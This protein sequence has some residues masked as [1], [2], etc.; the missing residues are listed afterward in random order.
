ISPRF[1]QDKISNALVSDKS[2]SSIN[3]FMVL[4]E[5]EAGVRKPSL[6]TN[7]EQ[8][9]RYRELLAA[10]RQEYEDTV[11]TAVERASSADEDGRGKRCA[12]YIDNG[13]ADTQREEV[14]NKYTGQYEEPG[15]RVRRSSE[16]KID[17]AENRQGDCRREIM[18]YIG[19]LAIE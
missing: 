18:N 14:R 15:E 10:V 17:V 13:K 11:K 16:E 4:S 7:E 5:L 9:E 3:P 19:A 12:S 2:E 1:V 6:I 8:R